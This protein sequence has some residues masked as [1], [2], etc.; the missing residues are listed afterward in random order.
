MK[1][2]PPYISGKQSLFRFSASFIIGT[3]MAILLL[4]LFRGP[5]LGFLYDFLLTKRPEL[6]IAREILIIDTLPFGT[7]QGENI[8]EPSA[9]ASLILVLT[10]FEASALILQVPIL[11][12]TAG[13]SAR[14]EEIRYHFNREFG[15]INR[16]TTNFFDAIRTGSIS[17]SESFMFVRELAELTER[18]KE[19]LINTLVNRD[20]EGL[21]RLEK[22]AMVFGNVR[23]P[24]DLI[25]QVIS[26]G[27]G[28]RPGALA[29][30]GGYSRPM[31][32]RDGVIRRIAPLRFLGDN[33]EEHIIYSALNPILQP[34]DDFFYYYLDLN[35]AL[36]FEVPQK[37]DFRRINMEEFLKYDEENQNL[38]RLLSEAQSSGLF[39]RIEGEENPVFLYDYA[40]A[41]LEDLL[42]D[43]DTEK[44]ALWLRARNDYF[45]SLE[46]YFLYG[47]SEINSHDELLEKYL[48]VLDLRTALNQA[49][50]DSFCILGPGFRTEQAAFLNITTLST[51]FPRLDQF[52]LNIRNLFSIRDLVAIRNLS[53]VEVSALLA[54]S[55]LLGRS[56]KP[57]D[58]LPL[59]G[60]AV[61]AAFFCA[62]LLRRKKPFSSLVLGIFFSFIIGFG[63]SLSFIFFGLW[64]DPLIPLLSAGTVTMV[65]FLW[66]NALR[67]SYNRKFRF[68]YGPFIS[69][70]GL[71]TLIRKGKPQ[72]KEIIVKNAAIVS[73]KNPELII[74]EDMDKSN[75]AAAAVMAFQDSAA[76][77]F[78]NAGGIIAGNGGDLVLACFGSPLEH[79]ISKKDEIVL[80]DISL[81]GAPVNRA[82]GFLADFVKSNDGRLWAFGLDFG[83]CAFSWSPLSGYSVFGRPVVRSRFLANLNMRYHTQ[84][85]VSG[86]VIEVLSD[87]PGKKLGSFKESD[88]S[89]SQPFYELKF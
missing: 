5:E 52:L 44:K 59:L 27:E 41:L 81:K 64:L 35:G 75:S 84:I 79:I 26:T 32:D 83:L 73:I 28:G 37:N 18:G 62:L 19:R 16:N 21:E 25:I 60:G 82:A 89:K 46:N 43:P 7:D 54:N 45:S 88:G 34:M 33:V 6:P 76:M 36:L 40:H 22:A 50:Q 2:R 57:G 80:S 47:S 72:P 39:S 48:E 30:S 61:L 65:S 1:Y 31:P 77:A 4:I 49:L 38:R 67:F 14:E 10:E 85:L 51:L 17:P 70:Q 86:S 58:E 74:Q 12:L 78:K 53:D 87:F 24:Q 23:R 29:E 11:G 20:E 3:A 56:I 42:E 69:S 8:L 13:S 9:A 55:M 71:K 63:F 68:S 66:A 15:L